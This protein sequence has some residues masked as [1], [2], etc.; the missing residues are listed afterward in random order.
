[1]HNFPHVPFFVK[2][3]IYLNIFFKAWLVEKKKKNPIYPTL[4]FLY[5]RQDSLHIN[6]IGNNIPHQTA[7][8]WSESCLKWNPRQKL[9]PMDP[10]RFRR[11]KVPINYTTRYQIPLHII[12]R[13]RTNLSCC[14]ILSSSIESMSLWIWPGHLSFEIR[15]N[16]KRE[17]ERSEVQK[18]R[19]LISGKS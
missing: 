17:R 13:P 18:H 2:N 10:F 19:L 11:Y 7:V 1:M 4:N 12:S 16:R 15:L 5:A 6:D 14:R 3:S 8:E 9:F